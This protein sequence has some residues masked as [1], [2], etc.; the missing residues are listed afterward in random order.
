MQFTIQK[1]RHLG[2]PLPF[3]IVRTPRNSFGYTFKLTLDF[4]GSIWGPTPNNPG[5][6]S[7]LVR[8]TPW[9]LPYERHK[10]FGL[11]FNAEEPGLLNI[12][13]YFENRKKFK[14]P[15]LQT[16]HLSSDFYTIE[17]KTISGKSYDSYTPVEIIGAVYRDWPNTT[18]VQLS[19]RMAGFYA[20]SYRKSHYS[21]LDPILKQS[22]GNQSWAWVTYIYYGGKAPAPQKIKLS[23][24]LDYFKQLHP[25]ELQLPNNPLYLAG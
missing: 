1:G 16:L 15:L 13:G 4:N 2:W 8:F 21:D 12:H 19:T 25:H 9:W 24:K 3:G 23:L 5:Q 10:S 18:T 17:N 7:K 20:G 14:T 22:L 11:G 6:V